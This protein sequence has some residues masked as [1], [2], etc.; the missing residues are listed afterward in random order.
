MLVRVQ[1][2][3]AWESCWILRL[4][5]EQSTTDFRIVPALAAVGECVAAKR[6]K[7]TFDGCAQD[8]S[9]CEE[10]INEG[11]ADGRIESRTQV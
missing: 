4:W 8:K 9:Q 6:L 7:D 5:S 11:L 10:D 1:D 2:V 3:D